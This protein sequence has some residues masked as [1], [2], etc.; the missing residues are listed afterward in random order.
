M[1]RF[2]IEH[3]RAGCLFKPTYA[4]TV[5]GAVNAANKKGWWQPELANSS[6]DMRPSTA[7]IYERY[8]ALW[9]HVATVSA[10]GIETVDN[11]S[12]RS[13]LQVEAQMIVLKSHMENTYRTMAEFNAIA[14]RTYKKSLKTKTRT[15][16]V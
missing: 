9:E 6:T 15:D 3:R 10:N 13:Y 4:T 14:D 16:D 5:I 1:K 11:Q 12:R 7:H 2:K 8:N